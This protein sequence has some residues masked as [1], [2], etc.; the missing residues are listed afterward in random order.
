MHLLIS[1]LIN[2]IAI[3]ITAA[4]L[5][6]VHLDGV[7]PALITAIVLGVINM[8]I[9]PIIILITLPLTILTLGLFILVINSLVILLAAAIVPGFTVDGFWWALIFSVV[10]WIVNSVLHEIESRIQHD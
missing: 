5:P 10:L 2:T 9:K 6:G 1:L 4:V 3:V 7:M 8:F